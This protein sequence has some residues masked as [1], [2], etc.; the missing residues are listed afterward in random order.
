MHSFHSMLSSILF[1]FHVVCLQ[2]TDASLFWVYSSC[3]PASSCLHMTSCLT[4]CAAPFSSHHTVTNALFPPHC[5]QEVFVTHWRQTGSAA[6][7]LWPSVTEPAGFIRMRQCE[8]LAQT[9]NVMV[10]CML[11]SCISA[12]AVLSLKPDLCSS[13]GCDS[14]G[15]VHYA[16]PQISTHCL[17]CQPGLCYDVPFT[18]ISP[19]QMRL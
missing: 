4:L 3:T 18:E 7:L 5:S 10:R 2:A 12:G 9:A 11:Y 8:P 6:F 1:P 16:N 13:T 14:V 19:P 17:G 15:F